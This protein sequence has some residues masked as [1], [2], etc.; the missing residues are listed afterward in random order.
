LDTENHP[1]VYREYPKV[2]AGVEVG[3]GRIKSL[4]QKSLS[5][6]GG[7]QEFFLHLRQEAEGNPW[8]SDL[9]R[10]TLD[11]KNLWNSSLI[12]G[13]IVSKKMLSCLH[14]HLSQALVTGRV[15]LHIGFPY[16]TDSLHE[17]SFLFTKFNN[18]TRANMKS[19]PFHFLAC[20]GLIF[21]AVASISVAQQGPKPVIL[22][23][24]QPEKFRDKKLEHAIMTVLPEVGSD[25]ENPVYYYYNRVDL[26]GDGKPEV[27]VYI[28]GA[29]VCGTG[30]CTALVF[31]AEGS[32]YKLISQITPARNP[33]VVSQ[34]RTHGW[35]DLIIFIAGGGVQPGYYAVLEFD[36][37][38]YPQNP[39][40]AP[41]KPLKLRSKGV[42][43]VNGN[44]IAGSGL[45]LRPDKK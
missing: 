27:L 29:P 43:Y 10:K 37:Q 13:Q 32:E 45:L 9:H 35:K 2:Y 28:F 6:I 14:H 19:R 7:W 22:R 26:N 40:V 21:F 1:V 11:C 5:N 17:H 42:A 34:T 41:A 23:R 33:I 24:A 25:S 38:Q 39:T 36:G 30:G 16:I 44:G 4:R 3:F 31:Q 15:G 20:M 12:H 18:F 8:A